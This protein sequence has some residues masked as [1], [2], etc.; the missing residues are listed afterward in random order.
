VQKGKVSLPHSAIV[1]GFPNSYIFVHCSR[2]WQQ[3][4]QTNVWMCSRQLGGDVQQ[5]T[6]LSDRTQHSPTTANQLT[7]WG[8]DPSATIKHSINNN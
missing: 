8:S 7:I 3:H 2:M 6:R 4:D 1:A 5:F